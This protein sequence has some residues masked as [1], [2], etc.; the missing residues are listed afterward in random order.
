M[1][2]LELTINE[3]LLLVDSLNSTL[4]Y[5][6]MAEQLLPLNVEDSIELE[7]LDKKWGVDGAALVAKLKTLDNAGANDLLR[8]VEAFWGDAAHQTNS[9]Q[10][11]LDVSL[12]TE[13]LLTPSEASELS[14]KSLQSLSGLAARGVI[15]RYSDPN[16]KNPQRRSRYLKREILALKKKSS[17]KEVNK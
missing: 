13:K 6:E 10:R 11:V 5:P 9:N 12:A 14:G 1:P 16:E 8:R 2:D 4:I 7:H 15:T 17:Q 3:A